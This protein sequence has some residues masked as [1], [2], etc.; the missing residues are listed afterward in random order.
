MQSRDS[1]G[2]IPGAYDYIGYGWNQIPQTVV[3]TCLSYSG[4]PGISS[5]GYSS[6][7]VPYGG[8]CD[9]ALTLQVHIAS[10]SSSTYKDQSV[11]PFAGSNLALFQ[12]S[13]PTIN[14]ADIDDLS[15][16]DV[17]SAN[18]WGA[19]LSQEFHSDTKMRNWR[20]H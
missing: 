19:T 8:N 4:I 17:I 3:R 20:Q 11:D 13:P 15:V 7:V 9:A 10:S 16:D 6:R 12:G 2:V 18:S 1:T 5:S 14:M